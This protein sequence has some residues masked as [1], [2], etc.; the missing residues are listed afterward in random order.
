MAGRKK[1]YTGQQELRPRLD[2]EPVRTSRGGIHTHGCC[3]CDPRG[4]GH[5]R[6]DVV[7]DAVA[8]PTSPAR[9][10]SQPQ[11]LIAAESLKNL[12]HTGSPQHFAVAE[13]DAERW[14]PT[15]HQSVFH[16]SL[17]T[18]GL[19][20][21]FTSQCAMRRFCCWGERPYLIPAVAGAP[22]GAA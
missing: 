11:W 3:G 20:C 13:N 15:Y 10:Q 14:L 5:L 6:F 7:K 2:N 22:A 8:L 16:Y 12:T 9:Q 17:K 1:L 21:Y 4:V 18:P 19:R